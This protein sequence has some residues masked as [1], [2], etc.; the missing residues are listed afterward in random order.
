[1]FYRRRIEFAA[2]LILLL[3]VAAATAR[4]ADACGPNF[5][6]TIL[7]NIDSKILWMPVGNLYQQLAEIKI[8]APP[9]CKANNPR[10]RFG[11]HKQTA[12]AEQ[13]DLQ[14]RF[15]ESFL[16]AKQKKEVCRQVAAVRTRIRKHAKNVKTWRQNNRK[17]PA[18]QK[19][20]RPDFGLVELPEELPQE[21]IL[22]LKGAIAYHSGDI[23]AARKHWTKLLALP[24]FLRQYRSTW[25]A[26]MLGESY[27]KTDPAKA[28]RYFRQ[29]RK[30][31]AAKFYDSLGLAAASLGEEAAIELEKK[32]YPKAVRL[33][34]QQMATGDKTA[35]DSLRLVANE[36]FFREKQEVLTKAVAD[37]VV[38]QVLLASVASYGGPRVNHWSHTALRKSVA[39]LLVAI[40]KNGANAVPHADKLAWAAYKAG[41]MDV[42]DRWLKRAD[43][44][45]PIAQWVQSKLLLRAGKIDQAATVLAGLVKTFPKEEAW[46]GVPGTGVRRYVKPA[47]RIAGELAA[48]R[49]R[50]G[51]YVESLDL[52]LRNGW[53]TDA[54]YVAE[55]VM[56]PEE[57][58]KYAREK[59]SAKKWP[60]KQIERRAKQFRYLVARRLGRLGRWKEAREFYPAITLK[61]TDAY[62]QAV[63]KGNDP[64]LSKTE[65]AKQFMV[66]ARL[67]RWYGMSMMG[68]ELW[69]DFSLYGGSYAYSGSYSHCHQNGPPHTYS[70]TALLPKSK[71]EIQRV[72]QHAAKPP[73]RFHYRYIAAEYAWAA[74]KLMP[75]N[76]KETAQVLWEAGRWLSHHDKKFADRFYKALVKRCGN[77]PLG[78]E[79]DKL[80]WFPK[81]LP[82]K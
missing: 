43:A 19:L 23:Q 21:F 73:K 76:S 45:S 33:Y 1:M 52:L 82:A 40:E 77:T 24:T 30:L 2:R 67:A 27:M 8:P 74:A 25:A 63:R 56:T 44:K 7:D 31:A 65:R 9:N 39:K 58:L 50:R 3:T 51:K 22:Y 55:Q 69:P 48:L 75:D 47:T 53:W 17:L 35:G 11:H 16:S 62:N 15:R 81:K 41:K 36:L 37:P 18:E 64:K 13:T 12:K 72:K 10:H 54:A 42:A 49:L 61:R 66:A 46:R 80:R 29:T 28:V 26:F 14:Q 32:D 20:R 79:A 5:P 68:T 34:L 71:A 70:K 59:W 4:P 57:L 6:D 38:L 60:N 78:K